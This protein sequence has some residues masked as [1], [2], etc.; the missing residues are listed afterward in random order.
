MPYKYVHQPIERAQLI[1]DHA[2]FH[3]QNHECSRCGIMAW[4]HMVR[5]QHDLHRKRHNGPRLWLWVR[6]LGPDKNSVIYSEPP[7]SLI[8]RWAICA[9]KETM[10]R[11]KPLKTWK[12]PW[13]VSCKGPKTKRKET[14]W[15]QSSI[16]GWPTWPCPTSRNI[17]IVT[18]PSPLRRNPQR[19]RGNWRKSCVF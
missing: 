2:P 4:F 16:N 9:R 14:K 11:G 7:S 17:A 12:L 19:R 6:S 3:L 5:M 18:V 8:C 15:S 10:L 1:N 13:G